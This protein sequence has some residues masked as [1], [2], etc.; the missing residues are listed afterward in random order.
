MIE[1]NEYMSVTIEKINIL[2]RF[3]YFKAAL[4]KIEQL[5]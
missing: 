5:E 2:F 1:I 3:K 4:S